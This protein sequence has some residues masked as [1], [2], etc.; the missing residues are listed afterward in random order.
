MP[1]E[2]FLKK[3]QLNTFFWTISIW[4]LT[5]AAKVRANFRITKRKGYIINVVFLVFRGFGWV[6]TVWACKGR[7]DG[8]NLCEVS[9][10]FSE[11]DDETES[12]DVSEIW[13]AEHCHLIA[14]PQA[15]DS[16]PS[17]SGL[18]SVQ[19]WL[20]CD[21]AIADREL[22]SPKK[23]INIGLLIK[24]PRDNFCPC[25]AA[26]LPS[27][28]GHSRD[29]LRDN[30]WSSNSIFS[31]VKPLQGTISERVRQG[32][33]LPRDIEMA[34]TALRAPKIGPYTPPKPWN[35]P[36]LKILCELY[37]AA[38]NDTSI[39]NSGPETSL[40]DPLPDSL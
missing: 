23:H 30:F 37:V 5:R 22:Q 18:S 20:H 3:A 6:L 4:F 29:N 9:Q 10:I 35:P 11:L 31:G 14:Q 25:L 26:Q 7:V 2:A 17:T 36:P 34:R 40:P 21:R 24:L 1:I 13:V 16:R 32:Q 8:V 38:K 33:K 28:V 39:K 12:S 19:N 27:P 15:L